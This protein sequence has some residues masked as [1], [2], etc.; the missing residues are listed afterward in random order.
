MNEFNE[1]KYS[2][3]VKEKWGATDAY[4]EHSA[5]TK[6]YTIKTAVKTTAVFL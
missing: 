3:E 4:R 1:S 2:T 6:N 5:K